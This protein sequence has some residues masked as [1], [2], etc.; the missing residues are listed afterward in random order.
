MKRILVLAISALFA[1]SCNKNDDDDNNTPVPA[2]PTAKVKYTNACISTGAL[3]AYINDTPVQGANGLTYLASSNY[4]NAKPATNAKHTFVLEDSNLPLAHTNSDLAANNYY[5]IFAA[6][7]VTS[8]A[9]LVV[10]DDLAAPATGMAKVRFINL[11]PDNLNE[12]VYVGNSKL[13]SN[14]AFKQVTPFRQVTAGTYQIIVQDPANVPSSRTLS[15]QALEAGKIY[16][17]MITGT[18]SGSGTT[19]LTLTLVNNL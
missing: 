11:S 16:T 18:V 1:V 17:L 19:A 3:R 2:T 13:D 6:G 14:I 5:T 12:T 8:P 10:Q 9:A 15:G 7:A 4:I